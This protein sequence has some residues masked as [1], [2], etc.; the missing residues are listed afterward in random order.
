[1][2]WLQ[3]IDSVILECLRMFANYFLLAKDHILFTNCTAAASS[4]KSIISH[5]SQQLTAKRTFM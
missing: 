3:N 1:M 4:H 2:H 5:Q